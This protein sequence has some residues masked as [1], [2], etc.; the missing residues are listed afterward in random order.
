VEAGAGAGGTPIFVLDAGSSGGFGGVPFPIKDGGLPPGFDASFLDAS[1]LI[2]N[3]E[4]AKCDC[5][6]PGR[7]PTSPVSP[8]ALLTLV[9]L[10]VLRRQPR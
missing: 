2:G 3:E 8:W 6:V 1:S 5:N 9:G 7:V 10:L 4:L